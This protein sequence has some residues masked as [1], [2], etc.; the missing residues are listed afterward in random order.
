[1][2]Q[3]C[4]LAQFFFCSVRQRI[5]VTEAHFLVWGMA[6][7]NKNCLLLNKI[8]IYLWLISESF[9]SS[10]PWNQITLHIEAWSGSWTRMKGSYLQ[11]H[12]KHLSLIPIVFAEWQSRYILFCCERML[13]PPPDGENKSTVKWND[14]L[15]NS[16]KEMQKLLPHWLWINH[17]EQK[18][19]I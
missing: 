15:S 5:H 7:A 2:L 10:D 8:Y 14:P 16:Y 9:I 6:I 13:L 4:S 19:D 12:I 17:A 11:I 18:T 1:M 3:V